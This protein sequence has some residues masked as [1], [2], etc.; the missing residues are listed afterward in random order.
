MRRTEVGPEF[1]A[2][3]ATRR[4]L[5]SVGVAAA[6]GIAC[7]FGVMTWRQTSPLEHA[8]LLVSGLLVLAG[9]VLGG[10]SR[11]LWL[12]TGGLVLLGLSA[13]LAPEG[14]PPWIPLVTISGYAAYVAVTQCS[15]RVGLV[16]AFVGAAALALVWSTQPSSAIPGSLVV[17]GG[18]VTVSQQL[19]GSLAMWWAW[20]T[21][22]AEA[23]SADL[24]ML[25]LQARTAA[26]IAV[27]ER[28]RLW[29]DMVT[30]VHESV[31]NSIHVVLHEGNTDPVRLSQ[32]IAREREGWREAGQ[33]VGNSLAALFDELRADVV[34]GGLVVVPVT[35]PPLG[36]D[37]DVFVAT[38]AALIE[39][40]RNAVRHGGAT[41]IV[42][43]YRQPAPGVIAIDIADNGIGMPRTTQGGIG[44]TTVIDAS[45]REVGG[46]WSIANNDKGSSTV[47]ISVPC[48]APEDPTTDRPQAYPPF[49]KGRLLVTAPLAGVSA[50]GALY[51]V[52]LLSIGGLRPLLA[53]VVGVIGSLAVPVVVA[54][55][56]RL[57]TLL[58]LVA[59]LAL[60]SVP[61]LLIGQ[62]SACGDATAV[63][64]AVSIAGFSMV[65]FMAWA[66]PV[67]GF[68]GLP[69]W[70]LG[71]ALLATG[72][73]SD[74][75]GFSL[76]GLLN[77]VIAIPI[78]L[79]VTT[80]G[81]RAYQ[82]AED[83]SQQARQ[84]EIAESSRAAA[85][86][87]VN[88]ALEDLVYEAL[89]ILSDVA[90]GSPLD[91]A[92][93][94]EL[95]R[96]DGRIRA[97]IQVDPQSDGGMAVLAKSL[98]DDV[99]SLGLTV[100]VRSLASSGDQ[101]PVPLSVQQV[102][103]QLLAT[104]GSAPA[105][106]HVFTDGEEDHLSMFVER[107]ALAAAELRLGSTVEMEGVTIE[108]GGAPVAGDALPD[109]AVLVSRPID[110]TGL[111]PS[112]APNVPA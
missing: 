8:V 30:R 36:L 55:R 107:K 56:R 85:A 49:D 50:V 15:R 76:V 103:Y 19:V 109:I 44:T 104:P 38:R 5:V 84:R 111:A 52:G 60:A 102:L 9:L 10:R 72:I 64:R 68:V 47:S 16:V 4:W 53:F 98:V 58:S 97:W 21:L 14:S 29:R 22:V 1:G 105:T 69:I 51:Y 86:V 17:W 7:V 70:G 27:Q 83:R 3:L 89:G 35:A 6:W 45:L 66:K 87:E 80:A 65:V 88:A 106:I 41:A 101:R 13:A 110:S 32:E 37:A 79:A 62:S 39:V 26:A 28:A 48:A 75:R 78:I 96:L 61:W 91:A 33:S 12:S 77:V 99:T 73:G 90:E 31:L 11:Y 108:V 100:T 54:R 95:E 23:E 112:L 81:A 94:Q 18:W 25:V 63:N 93:R 43:G 82:R 57:S 40:S 20:N 42:V 24:A 59:V 71:T 74:C 92:R 67:A 46:S 2:L 34:V